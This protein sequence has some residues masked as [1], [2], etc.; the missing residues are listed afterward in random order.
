MALRDRERRHGDARP[1]SPTGSARCSRC[2]FDASPVSPGTVPCATA[3]TLPFLPASS[4]R[5]GMVMV[6]ADGEFDVVTT[7]ERVEI[8]APVYDLDIARTHNFVADGI[9]THNSIYKFR[10]ADYRNL[11]KFEETFPDATIIVLDQNYR[12]TQRILDAANAVIA[13]NA[14]APAEAPLDRAGRR[15]ADRALRGGGRARRG[16]VRR[17]RDP[18]A[19][20]QRRSPLRRHRGLL[21]HQ[22]AE[23]R[24]RGVARTR[25][26][27][28]PRVRR[29]EVLRPARGE[30]RARVPARAREPRRRGVVEAHR[31]HAQARRRRHVGREGL[32]VRAG[33]GRHV[34]RGAAGRGDRGRQRAGR[35]AASATCSTCSTRSPTRPTVESG[36]RSR[37]CSSAPATSPSCGPS[38]RSSRRAASRTCRS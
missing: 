14:A 1:R 9:V 21:P 26:H 11:A 3:N 8:D 5:P 15:R 17:R 34:P 19:H 33:R 24:R 4:V 23:P 12:S 38:A 10:G 22:R 35:S 27:P 2:R 36:T 32:G 30:G 31:Q 25:G 37:P 28:V 6:D 16:V 20:R 7:V 29:R 13:N 18:P